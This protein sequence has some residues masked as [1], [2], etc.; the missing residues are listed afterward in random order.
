VNVRDFGAV[1]DG[2]SHPL[3]ERY[4]T[5]SE[6]QADYPH[7]ETLNDEIDWAAIQAA[8]KVAKAGRG[9]TVW[10]P[11]GTYICSKQ[12]NLDNT[13]NIRLEG[14]GRETVIK[15]RVIKNSQAG[16]SFVS[17]R[18]SSFFSIRRLTLTSPS[19]TG[20]AQMM[21]KGFVDLSQ[22]SPPGTAS[23]T[24]KVEDSTKPPQAAT[25]DLSIAFASSPPAL[26]ITTF[27]MPDATLGS[28]YSATLA[29]SWGTTPY[30]WSLSGG[31]LPA[32]LTLNPLT[33]Q[34]LGSPTTTGT[35][36][37]TVNVTDATTPNP[38]TATQDLSINVNGGGTSAV[39]I[40]TSSLPD[41]MVGHSYS[42]RLTATGGT[43]PYHWSLSGGSLPAN[44]TLNPSTG[45]IA[46]GPGA[47]QAL[48][49]HCSFVDDYKV[50]R[51]S[52]FISLDKAI[53]C[54]IRNNYFYGARV[55]I[56]GIGT[57]S[58]PPLYSNVNLILNNTFQAQREATITN[59]GDGW[60]IQGN[61]FEPV[62][63]SDATKDGAAAAYV[64][65]T[66]DPK[67]VA[68]PHNVSFIGNWFGDANEN[69]AWINW[70]GRDLMVL[71][72]FFEGGHAA[73][74]LGRLP[75]SSYAG[76]SIMGNYFQNPWPH[77]YIPTDFGQEDAS[78]QADVVILG[79]RY[80]G[81]TTPIVGTFPTGTIYQTGVGT[82]GIGPGTSTGAPKTGGHQLGELYVDSAGVLWI[83]TL[84]GT[85]GTWVKVGSQV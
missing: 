62:A 33:G 67:R 76:V 9:G 30:T 31:S 16:P 39:S 26:S 42:A 34:I 68:P 41:G 59:A 77:E 81:V 79:N 4:K 47:A 13:E 40:T 66:G 75:G 49:E 78:G 14:T 80:D 72:N 54:T 24:V 57:G 35:A 2:L 48:I 74:A 23:F 27:S 36:S 18:S 83:C 6:A 69:G 51:I 8:I 21:D 70:W 82:V 85:P 29:A 22:T 73:I 50:G 15:N 11:T 61:T 52:I 65:Y 37:F 53:S 17:A 25:K 84:N 60:L 3:S 44:L 45:E 5:L 56:R 38:E 20:L 19:T 46:S 1:G 63:S 43:S 28:S 58:G 7:A 12:L 64:A 71:G 32:G 55:A 10:F